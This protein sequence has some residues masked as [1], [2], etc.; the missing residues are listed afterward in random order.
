MVEALGEGEDGGIP[1]AAHGREDRADVLLDAREV[2]LASRAQA[3]E[4]R[5]R[6]GGAV[7]ER[8]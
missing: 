4:R 3:V 1:R 7:G 2:R 6:F 8:S 5:D